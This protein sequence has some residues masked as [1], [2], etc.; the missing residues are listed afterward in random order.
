MEGRRERSGIVFFDIAQLSTRLSIETLCPCLG[1]CTLY[2]ASLLS[3]V[4]PVL[5]A[6]SRL[7]FFA[8][9]KAD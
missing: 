7:T 2:N 1:V 4:T 8:V 3:F 9:D 6:S 5:Q